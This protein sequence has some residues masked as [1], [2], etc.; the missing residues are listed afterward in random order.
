VP[1]TDAV[2]WGGALQVR[3]VVLVEAVAFAT[4]AATIGIAWNR[5]RRRPPPGPARSARARRPLAGAA[6][7]APGGTCLAWP[8]R[9]AP[10]STPYA[11]ARALQQ[12]KRT[13]SI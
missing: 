10:R 4:L 12:A 2:V 3:E 8:V 13:S 9:T 11:A 7:V 6:A 5:S 1:A